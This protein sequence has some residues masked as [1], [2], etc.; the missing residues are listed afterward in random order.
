MRAVVAGGQLERANEARRI[1]LGE[2]LSCEADGV[3]GYDGLPQ[4]LA[5]TPPDLVLIYCTGSGHESLE[6]IRTAHHLVPS[7][8]LAIGEPAVPLVREAMRAGASEYLDVNNLRKDLLAA[9]SNIESSKLE[10]AASGTSKRGTA[11]AI[12]SPIGGVGVTTIAINLAVSLARLRQQSPGGTTALVDI[13]P[14]PSDLSLL[15]D[16]HPKHTLADVCRHWEH[17]DR[18]LLA[19]AMT[20][21]ASGLQVLAQAGYEASRR[22][23]EATEVHR[24]SFSWNLAEEPPQS[25]TTNRDLEPAAVRQL[26]VLLRRIYET[27]VVDMGHATSDSQ[28]EAMRQSNMVLLVAA[29]DVPGLRRV[30]WAL[31]MVESCGV[32]RDRF[33]L[34]VNRSGG[35]Q[36]VGRARVEEALSMPVLAELPDN[37]PLATEARNEGAVLIDL[38]GAGK[39][40]SAYTALA[41]QIQQLLVGVPA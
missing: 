32:P 41:T 39:I 8:I 20:P 1:L 25:G 23:E 35:R 4:C 31:E 29:A 6:A 18:K 5:A 16:L 7:P 30:R 34:I 22:P 2:G 33:Q 9:L 15:L 24:P 28:I 12:F 38:A 37:A 10:N 27:V 11:T 14:A 13:A 26:F 19:A 40:R 17:M 36:Q 3:V 21:H